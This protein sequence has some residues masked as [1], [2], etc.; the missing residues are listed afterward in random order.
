M[1]RHTGRSAPPATPVAPQKNPDALV[2]QKS[3]GSF[4]VIPAIWRWE[5]YRE[6]SYLR[7]ELYPALE[8]LAAFWDDYMTWDASASRY[9][10]EH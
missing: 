4:A 8:E 1:G 10:V 5:Y 9:V 2:D 7:E 3:N 6:V